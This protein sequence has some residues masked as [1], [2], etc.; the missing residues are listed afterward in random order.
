MRVSEDIVSK[1]TNF[2]FLSCLLTK[3]SIFM[4]QSNKNDFLF[5]ESINS[6]MPFLVSFGH[7]DSADKERLHSYL[8]Q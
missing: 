8:V 4:E 5:D 7:H 2:P 6:A 1:Y 3:S